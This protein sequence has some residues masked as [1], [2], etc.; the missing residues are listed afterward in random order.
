MLQEM[1]LKEWFTRLEMT[2]VIRCTLHL[3][4]SCKNQTEISGIH[5][6]CQSTEHKCLEILLF[7]VRQYLFNLNTLI[8]CCSFDVVCFIVLAFVYVDILL[9][10]ILLYYLNPLN[11]CTNYSSNKCILLLLFI[12][13]FTFILEWIN[14]TKR[15]KVWCELT[16]QT[17]PCQCKPNL[18]V[19]FKCHCLCAMAFPRFERPVALLERSQ[20]KYWQRTTEK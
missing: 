2:R 16:M 14:E 4:V 6:S 20:E 3:W 17:I 10:Y 13:V 5:T 1:S 19:K 12:N 15:V 11:F 7:I 8:L 18:K 9:L